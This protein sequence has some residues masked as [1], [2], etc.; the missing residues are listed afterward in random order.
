[1]PISSSFT[2][3]VLLLHEMKIIGVDNTVIDELFEIFAFSTFASVEKEGTRTLMRFEITH[4]RYVRVLRGVAAA[5]SQVQEIQT[6]P[7]GLTS[8]D[9]FHDPQPGRAGQA[10][11]AA[12]GSPR[13][14]QAPLWEWGHQP[15]GWAW[16]S[17]TRAGAGALLRWSWRAELLQRHW[18]S[19]W[20][21]RPS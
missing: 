2:D 4:V 1:M 14:H 17:R 5:W 20:Q 13:H 3:F 8:Q 12:G 10:R 6:T 18:D 9:L 15:V 21:L 16:L 7:M 19:G 11:R